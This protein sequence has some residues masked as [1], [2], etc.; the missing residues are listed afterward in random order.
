MFHRYESYQ[1]F[2]TR[3][4]SNRINIVGLRT[5]ESFRRRN[6]IAN[7]KGNN[8]V[9]PI[10]DWRD[11]DVWRYIKDFKVEFPDAYLFMYQIGLSKRM[12]RISQF[13]SIDTARSLVQMAEFY[14]NL[15]DRIIKREPNAY[16]ATLYW[17]TEIFR[18]AEQVSKPNEDGTFEN[19]DSEYY[20]KKFIELLSNNAFFI[21]DSSKKTQNQFK[22]FYFNHGA[23]INQLEEKNRKTVFK[24]MYETVYGGDPKTRRYQTIMNTLFSLVK[25]EYSQKKEGK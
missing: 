10:Y 21:T 25:K 1:E 17:D 22:K 13:F 15:F 16:L 9:Y 18:K 3:Y 11:S 19:K 7:S 8:F 5:S 14:P 12:L 23:T 4:A 20:K 2:L 6:G 24:E